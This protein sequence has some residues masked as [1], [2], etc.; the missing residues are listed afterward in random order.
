MKGG[1]SGRARLAAGTVTR[2]VG[3]LHLGDGARSDAF[4]QDDRRLVRFL[5]DCEARCDALVFM[6]DA[7]DL[8]QAFSTRRVARAHGEAVRAIERLVGRVQVVFV[9][10]NHD[11][12][13]TY[14][15]LF[16]R[17]RACGELE[18]GDIRVIH[19]HQLDRYCHPGRRGH[20]LQVSLHHLA[21]RLFGFEFRVPLSEHDTWR[22]RIA[23]WL[24]AH[25]GGHLRSTAAVYRLFG[26]HER[27]A[28]HRHGVTPTHC[29]IP[30]ALRCDPVR[31]VR[32]CAAS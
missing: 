28:E 32:S 13:V 1:P 20:H 26:L 16:P 8:P 17:A 10:G 6:R 22:N 9:L 15:R 29:S 2:F 19:G 7:F 5:A 4:G 3:D 14:E 24:G 21:E 23:H 18:I 30:R 11:W 12:M 25:Y 27:A 31:V